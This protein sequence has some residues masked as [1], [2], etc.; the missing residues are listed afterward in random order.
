MFSD[1][2]DYFEM[3]VQDR[4]FVAR[5]LHF[6]AGAC[7]APVARRADSGAADARALMLPAPGGA[8]FARGRARP[9]G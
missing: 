7:P 1:Q 8:G 4:T 3:S 5:H 9:R 2:P 6:A